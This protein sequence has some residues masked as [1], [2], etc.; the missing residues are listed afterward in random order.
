MASKK[1]SAVWH[2]I[3]GRRNLEGK[4]RLVIAMQQFTADLVEDME[5]SATK[6]GKLHT[7]Q[8]LRAI[9]EDKIEHG[10]Q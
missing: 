5:Q 1:L 9:T 3:F 8:A 2:I 6:A 4:M 10:G 7:L